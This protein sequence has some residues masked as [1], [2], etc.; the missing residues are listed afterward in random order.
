MIIACWLLNFLQQK[1]WKS[2]GKYNFYGLLHD[3][4]KGGNGRR[5]DGSIQLAEWRRNGSKNAAA[6][7]K[8]RSHQPTLP[9][10]IEKPTSLEKKH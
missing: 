3:M 7:P 5:N 4:P 9:A 1:L 8:T 6:S 10:D 2:V